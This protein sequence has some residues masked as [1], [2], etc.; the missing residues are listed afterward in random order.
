MTENES[1][2]DPQQPSRPESEYE[3]GYAKGGVPGFL[4][5]VYVVFLTFS[6]LYLLDYLI[7]SWW[8][9]EAHIEP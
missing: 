4:V 2:P 8:S 3:F 5:F 9:L 6:M 7:P 1:G